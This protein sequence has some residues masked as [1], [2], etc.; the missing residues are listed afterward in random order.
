MKLNQAL[1]GVLCFFLAIALGT[2]TA[3]ATTGDG[4]VLGA[5][6]IVDNGP[7]S[8]RF[9][10]VII[11]EGYQNDE[12][13]LFEA[14]VQTFVNFLFATPPFSTSSSA[15]NVW[16]IN[17]ASDQSG[18]DDPTGC[19]GTGAEVD[20]YFDA[21]FCIGGIRRL[22]VGNTATAINALDAHVPEWDHALIIVNST[23]YGGSGGNVAFTSVGGSWRDVAVHELGHAA[24]GLADEYEYWAGCGIDTDRDN[25]PAVEPAEPNV[26]IETDLDFVK[27]G[28]LIL[29]T[30][31]VPTTQ[32]ADCTQCDTQGNPYLGQTVV[33]LY[34]GAHYYHCDV[35]RPA[36]NC[37]MRNFEPFCPV[38]TRRILEVL[39]PF[40]APS[41]PI[42]YGLNW[43]RKQQK[44][45]GSWYDNPG[46]TAL[47]TL[48]FLNAGYTEEDEV[49]KDAID[50]IAGFVQLNGSFDSGWGYSNYETS[51]CILPLVATHNSVYHDMIR[52]AKNYL[53]SIQ[54]TETNGYSP[55]DEAYGGWGYPRNNWA[56]LSNTQ[57]TLMGLHFAYEELGLSQEGETWV[58]KALTWV[59]HCQNNDSINDLPFAQGRTD[60]GLT[61]NPSGVGPQWTNESYASM[62]YAGIWSYALLGLDKNSDEIEAALGWVENNYRVYA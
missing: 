38:C 17:V 48:A 27:W 40:I 59:R 8:D 23:V 56:D 44:A 51:I 12:Q 37:M 41:N 50:Y 46:V 28:D 60:G 58:D 1:I 55:S 42:S 2:T 45:N 61:Y 35:F 43:L 19:G 62:T 29:V 30:T 36:F 21:S 3:V 16:R 5:T 13:N 11:G 52:N 47:S 33:G 32:N 34:E 49:V 4:E 39:E 24:F 14:H 53:L 6:K 18:A 10:L 54:N 20:T 7:A 15:L 31:P 25:H 22:L 26:T 57:W 9:N